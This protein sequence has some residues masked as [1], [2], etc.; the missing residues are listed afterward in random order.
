[1]GF[2]RG[3]LLS[4]EPSLMP[5]LANY[6]TEIL[7]VTCI[8]LLLVVL[9]KLVAILASYLSNLFN[10]RIRLQ[11]LFGCALVGGQKVIQCAC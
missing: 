10:M 3:F 4:L 6:E 1:M 8:L 7:I 9:C 11:Y 5:G 2:L